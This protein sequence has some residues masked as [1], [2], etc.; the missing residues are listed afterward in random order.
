MLNEKVIRMIEGGMA[1]MTIGPLKSLS[2]AKEMQFHFLSF[3][4][5]SET[6]W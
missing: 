6:C 2:I 4:L 5:L 1:Q 3:Y